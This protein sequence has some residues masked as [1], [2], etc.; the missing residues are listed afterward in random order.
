MDE[1]IKSFFAKFKM[2]LTDLWTNNKI[3]VI[4]FGLLI[5]V[6][7]FRS[8]LIDLIVAGGKKQVE[9]ATAKD[10]VLAKEESAANDQA[11][12]LVQKAANEPGKDEPVTDDWNKKSGS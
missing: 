2:S 4:I 8:V 1:K 6:F 7:K 12:A 9:E 5:V 3:F 10:A 11:N